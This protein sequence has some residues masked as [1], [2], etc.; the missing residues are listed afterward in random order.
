M[1]AKVLKYCSKES[2]LKLLMQLKSCWSS[3]TNF[4]VWAPLED[5]GGAAESPS[6]GLLLL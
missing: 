6:Q 5:G 1:L 3:L 2:M 4:F